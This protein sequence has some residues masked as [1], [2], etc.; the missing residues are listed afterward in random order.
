MSR[1]AKDT[2]P[3]LKG[4]NRSLDTGLGTAKRLAEFDDRDRNVVLVR[5]VKPLDRLE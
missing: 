4:P 3:L 1:L 5:I 2:A